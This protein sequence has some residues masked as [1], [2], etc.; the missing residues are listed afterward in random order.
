MKDATKF[1]NDIAKKRTMILEGGSPQDES[2][3]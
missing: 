1:A 2:S 3:R